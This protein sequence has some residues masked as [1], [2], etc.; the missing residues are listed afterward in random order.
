[1]NQ[2]PTVTTN[3]AVNC[4]AVIDPVGVVLKIREDIAE[5]KQPGRV[6][7]WR[8]EM[9]AALDAVLRRQAVV[10]RDPDMQLIVKYLDKQ[11]FQASFLPTP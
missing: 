6:E 10:R 2:K 5:F 3:A 8:A 4:P 11:E 7:A 1:M 9:R